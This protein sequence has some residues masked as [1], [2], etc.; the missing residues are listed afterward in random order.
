MTF[1]VVCCAE[2]F[3]PRSAYRLFTSFQ[4]FWKQFWS[5]RRPCSRDHS[6]LYDQCK[7]IKVQTTG[8][9]QTRLFL[10]GAAATYRVGG[11]VAPFGGGLFLSVSEQKCL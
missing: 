3:P 11:V 1:F 5:T 6:K 9:I 7:C 10:D 4:K 8:M 2:V